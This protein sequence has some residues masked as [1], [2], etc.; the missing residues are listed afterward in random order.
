MSKKFKIFNDKKMI[1]ELRKIFK[2]EK[3][4]IIH[5]LFDGYDEYVVKT[6]AVE[7]KIVWY[8][9]NSRTLVNNP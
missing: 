6:I 5:S 3:P 4:A 8:Y 1:L 7:N 2:K 9:H